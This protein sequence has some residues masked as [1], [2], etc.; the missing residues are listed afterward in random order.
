MHGRTDISQPPLCAV[1]TTVLGAATLAI[2]ARLTDS[3]HGGLGLPE[4][5]ESHQGPPGGRRP[6]QHKERLRSHCARYRHA[7]GPRQRSRCAARRV[8]LTMTS[9]VTATGVASPA[10]VPS[11]AVRQGE[12]TGLHRRI[13]PLPGAQAPEIEPPYPAHGAAKGGSGSGSEPPR[14]PW[15]C[16]AFTCGNSSTHGFRKRV[17][18]LGAMLSSRTGVFR[19]PDQRRERTAE[20]V[21]RH[22]APRT[23]VKS[24]LHPDL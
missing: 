6:S 1:R 15:P 8:N 14:A 21:R 18:P 9:I 2:V 24:F 20:R 5:G 7:R 17:T 22:R 13:Q 23:G 12:G 16:H 3:L 10:T 19:R 11:C 4:L